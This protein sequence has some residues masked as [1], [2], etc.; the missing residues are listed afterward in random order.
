[1]E[2]VKPQKPPYAEKH[3][4]GQPSANQLELILTF[5]RQEL[6]ERHELCQGD[7]RK[8]AADLM[9]PTAS[10]SQVKLREAAWAKR[11]EVWAEYHRA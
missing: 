7:M 2:V 5:H 8:L 10:E 3:Y 9:A 6:F 4:R 1:M 11:D